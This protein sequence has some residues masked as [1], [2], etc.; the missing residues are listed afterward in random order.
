MGSPLMSHD[1]SQPEWKDLAEQASQE[2]DTAKLLFLV[3]ELNRVLEHGEQEAQKRR[4]GHTPQ[5]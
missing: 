5:D 1:E 4:S 3:T 2:M